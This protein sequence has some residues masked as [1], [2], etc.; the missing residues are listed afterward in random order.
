MK[1]LHEAIRELRAEQLGLDDTVTDHKYQEELNRIL[2]EEAVENGKQAWEAFGF[3]FANLQDTVREMV[4]VGQ[5]EVALATV[6][7]DKSMDSL[8]HE[9]IIIYLQEELKNEQTESN[10]GSDTAGSG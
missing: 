4:R 5:V 10:G 7:Q 3:E 2:H 1:H 8:D 6:Q 9:H